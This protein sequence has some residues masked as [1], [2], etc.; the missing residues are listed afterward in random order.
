[1]K[2]K[3][4]LLKCFGSA[5][6][7]VWAFGYSGQV[8]AST[9]CVT[10][11]SSLTVSAGNIVVQ[12]DAATGSAISNEI[13]GTMTATYTCT[14][15]STGTQGGEGSIDG[16]KS[17]L[18]S[19]GTSDGGAVIYKTNIPGVGMT[20][21]ATD[22]DTNDE[23]SGSSVGVSHWIGESSNSYSGTGYVGL[24]GWSSS[25]NGRHYYF[26]A[27][28][29]VKF[30]KIGT[31]QSGTLSGSFASMIMGITPLHST[32]P[33]RWGPEIPISFAS[34]SV[35]VLAC[36][37]KTPTLTFPIGDVTATAFGTSVGTTPSS[38]QNTQNLG[39]DCDAKANINASLAGTQN[40][41]VGTTSVLA[42]TGQGNSDVAQGVGVQ[43]LY[44]G[45]PLVL[46]NR[47]VLKQS[48]GGQETLPLTARYYQ[49]KSTVTPGKANASA[50]LNL[51]YQ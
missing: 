41:D 46:N 47:I 17:Y 6:F 1:M 35:T 12:R 45:S 13:D 27:Q 30:Y 36:S 24:A 38:A 21:G 18:T 15:S 33:S 23:P 40:P 20:I 5:L 29:R 14:G 49:T 4:I 7:S 37:I 11:T 51:T 8:S 3:Y 22:N 16:I 2:K 39:L 43:I 44:N 42:L 10:N 31:I 25:N 9:T 19:N 28:T 34:G 26:K 48:A 50:T 32:T